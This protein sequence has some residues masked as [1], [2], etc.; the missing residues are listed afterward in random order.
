MSELF[1][2]LECMNINLAGK[3]QDKYTTKST[4]VKSNPASVT[5]KVWG[6]SE[7]YLDLEN[8]DKKRYK[9]NSTLLNDKILPDLNVSISLLLIY[10]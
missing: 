1:R 2:N 9:E 6:E 3:K 8:E 10:L 5:T 4:H 7:Y